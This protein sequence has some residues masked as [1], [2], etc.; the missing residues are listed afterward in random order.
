MHGMCMNGSAWVGGNCMLSSHMHCE[1]E[2]IPF[3]FRSVGLV[4]GDFNISNLIFNDQVR[5][6]ILAEAKVKH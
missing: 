2:C 6:N 5:Y 3:S 4:H 1:G